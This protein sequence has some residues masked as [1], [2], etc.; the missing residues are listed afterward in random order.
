MP[1][2]A[3]EGLTAF[4]EIGRGGFGVVYRAHQ[5]S[6]DRDIAVKVLPGVHKD[7]E[8]FARFERE[9]KAL[10]S[11]GAHPNIATVYGCGVT[12]DGEGFLAMELL[13]GGSLA[14]RFAG[15]PMSW[16]E[17]ARIGVA[18]SGALES[19]HRLGV[20]HRDV[21]PQN[22][23]FDRLGTPKLMDFGIASVP[24]AYQTRTSAVSLTLAH[25]A[26]E[27]TAGGRATVAS[28]VYALGSTL[29]TA[30]AGKA[31]FVREGEDTLIP[32]LARIAASPVPPLPGGDVSPVLSALLAK[33]MAKDP[34]GRPASAEELGTGLAYVLRSAGETVD[35]PAVLTPSRRSGVPAGVAPVGRRI[36]ADPVPRRR[37]RRRGGPAGGRRRGASGPASP[38]PR[39]GGGLPAAVRLQRA[40]HDRPA[41]PRFRWSSGGGASLPPG[42]SSA[43]RAGR[44]EVRR[45]AFG[46][47]VDQLAPAV[48]RRLLN[49]AAADSRVARR[50]L[51]D[52]QHRHGVQPAADGGADAAVAPERLAFGVLTGRLAALA[53]VVVLD[54][55]GHAV[56]LGHEL[57]NELTD[58][59][60]LTDAHADP[61]ARQA[62]RRDVPRVVVAG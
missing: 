1:V 54:R 21:K 39:R 59:V 52:R 27:I 60:T 32:L 49:G 30:A 26:P 8:S 18:L 44:A 12:T 9:C 58:D 15:G 56:E 51:A 25:A 35:G 62:R 47:S 36:R 38:G 46:A 40:R 61:R 2:P 5:E 31:P 20:L 16:D 4:E 50:H 45:V 33:S 42:T 7:S 19:A 55:H 28:D 34:A 14:D 43:R 37:G 22:V 48:G 11:V 53:P 3:V 10:G 6:L 23:L 57:G 17:V 41:A 24:G 13:D 29:W